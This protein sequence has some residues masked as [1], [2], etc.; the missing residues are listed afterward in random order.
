AKSTLLPYT[1]LFRSI[2]VKGL[3]SIGKNNRPF[4]NNKKAKTNILTNINSRNERKLVQMKNQNPNLN[5]LKNS[6][7]SHEMP[8]QEPTSNSM[9]GQSTFGNFVPKKL[10]NP[11][12]ELNDNVDQI[13]AEGATKDDLLPLARKDDLMKLQRARLKQSN[14]VKATITKRMRDQTSKMIEVA[15]DTRDIAYNQGVSADV[16][17]VRQQVDA[18]QKRQD[19][20]N[21]HMNEVTR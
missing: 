6:K 19:T 18:L 13:L 21:I 20:S 12:K 5:N 10:K 8:K 9:P 1:T 7:Q 17:G 15:K 16:A 11:N 14:D 4:L 2:L 3:K